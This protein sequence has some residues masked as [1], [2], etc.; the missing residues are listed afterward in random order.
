MPTPTPT[1]HKPVQTSI[2]KYAE[3]IYWTTVS[4]E[5]AE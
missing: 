2:F 1:E 3:A 4:H 5:E